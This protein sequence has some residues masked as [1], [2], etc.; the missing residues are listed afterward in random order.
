METFNEM[1]NIET[2]MTETMFD[3]LVTCEMVNESNLNKLINS[4]L[5]QL[6]C[7]QYN[8]K[9]YENEKTQLQ[10]YQKI[11]KDGFAHVQ[12]FKQS[13]GR[14]C[15]NKGLSLLNIRREIRQTICNHDEVVDIDIDNA[16]PVIMLQILQHNKIKCNNLKCYVNDRQHYR[17]TIYNAW[18]LDQYKDTYSEGILK[19]MSKLLMLRIMYGGSIGAWEN[20]FKLKSVDVPIIIAEFIA[21]FKNITN[22][23]TKS[24][25]HL[26][27]QIQQKKDYNIGGSVTS[28]I[29]LQK[30]SQ[31]LEVM[32]KYLIR[33]HIIEMHNGNPVCAMCADG[34]I[35][36]KKHFTQYTLRELEVEIYIQTGFTLK[37]STKPMTQHYCDILDDHIITNDNDVLFQAYTESDYFNPDMKRDDNNNTIILLSTKSIECRLCKITHKKNNQ[38]LYVNERGHICLSC[39]KRQIIIKHTDHKAIAKELKNTEAN[40]YIDDFYTVTHDESVKVINEE[41]KYISCDVND[42]FIYRPEYD[43]SKYIILHAQMG[44]GKTQMIKKI[45][46]Q[47]PKSSILVVSQRIA[48]SHFIC[49]ELKEFNVDLYL[50]LKDVN[51][52]KN[53]CIQVESLHKVQNTYDIV[54]ID[55]CEAVINQISAST[56]KQVNNCYNVLEHIVAKSNITI[57]ADAFVTNRAVKYINLFKSKRDQITMI[58]NTKLYLEDRKAIQI[59]GK[60][61]DNEIIKQLIQNKKICVVSSSKTDALTLERKLLKHELLKNKVIKYYDKDSDKDDL[62]DVNESWEKADCVI[63]TPTITVGISYTHKDFDTIYVNAK[64]TCQVRDIM[65]MCLRI[66]Y[67]KENQ[68]YFS[69]SARQMNNSHD[70]IF[71]D[72]K[73]FMKNCTSKSSIILKQVEGDENIYDVV[74]TCVSTQNEDL[75]YIMHLNLKETMISR[76]YFNQLCIY[77]FKLQGYNVIELNEKTVDAEKDDKDEIDQNEAYMNIMEITDNEVHQLKN[78]QV[79]REIQMRI[80]K[81]Y[82]EKLTVAD[83]DIETKSKL[84]YDYYQNTYKKSIISNLQMEKSNIDTSK[85][86]MKD[87]HDAD[88]LVNKMSLKCIKLDH[89]RNLNKILNLKYSCQTG[90]VIEKQN[91]KIMDYMKKNVRSINTVY[92]TKY[93]FTHNAVKNSLVCVSMLEKIYYNWSGVKFKAHKKVHNVTESYKIDGYDCYKSINTKTNHVVDYTEVMLED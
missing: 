1:F 36:N 49:G 77:L 73:Q 60:D 71:D 9:A 67:L 11:I 50:D 26:V 85:I 91:T 25:P 56:V 63:Y 39:H 7:T 58:K 48:Y 32:I 17:D 47:N 86:I 19:D 3:G 78:K 42:K 30:E 44:K 16:H 61:F 12:N 20:Q 2:N 84:F 87:L 55:E 93:L 82:F 38:K 57:F 79:S 27:K 74:K 69:L 29:M 54:I 4:D 15:A 6:S 33:R 8:N 31:I 90:K 37:L 64:N 46:R 51:K 10:E 75:Q 81:Y 72:F 24:N 23:F 68:I 92:N 13:I 28:T 45:L 43:T 34:L 22:I 89:I 70:F 35:I 21:E 65:Q 5:L 14:S 41:S 80:D 76:K 59:H 53:L 62:R 40:K 88:N 18:N 66:R 83:L 52:S